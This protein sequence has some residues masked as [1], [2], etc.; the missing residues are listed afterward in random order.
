MFF[1]NSDYGWVVGGD[2]GAYPT[3]TPNREILFTSNGGSTWTTQ[4]AQSGETPLNAIYF[5]DS[6]SGFAVGESGAIMKTTNGGNNWFQ[7]TILTGY[8][9]R[10]ITFV[11][12]NTGWMIGY[13]LGLPH[14]SAV[15]KT[16]DGGTTWSSQSFGT[17][18]SFSSIT[19]AD[20]LNGWA[21]GGKSSIS[22]SFII[23]TSDGGTTWEYQD[24]PTNEFLM[25]VF[26]S[27]GNTGWAVGAG[28]IVLAT[29]SAVPVELTSFT[30][31][32]IVNSV[33]LEWITATETNN[34]GFEIYRSLTNDNFKTIGFVAGHGTTT[35]VN[36]YSF[37]D[38]KLQSGIY[39][40]KLVQIDYDG[41][42]S[43]TDIVKVE[44][45]TQPKGFSLDQNFPNPFNPA[46]NISF[47]LPA[48]GETKLRIFN[49]IG[50]EIVT[51]VDEFREAGTYKLNFNASNLTSG[52]YYYRIESADFTSMKKM[53]LLR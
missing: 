33:K 14:T 30:A 6:N 5:I 3:F 1:I 35:K 13:Y 50:E 19:F 11:N 4:Y 23:H 8:E 51:L 46:T 34:S 44:L 24:N 37:L 45:I 31:S 15:F 47:T 7:S 12:S 25:K 41:T 32:A 29:E 39:S 28:G 17:D 16:I 10:D 27:D 38:E 48:A 40:Y 53:I 36:N 18:E 49:A 2:H 43:E 52:V 20:E 9:L 21:V 26:F 42:T 22:E